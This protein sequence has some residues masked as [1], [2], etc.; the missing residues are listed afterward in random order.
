MKDK[1]GQPINV[2]DFIAYGH[3]RGGYSNS[4]RIG[5]VLRLNEEKGSLTVQGV[6]DDYGVMQLTGSAGNLTHPHRVLVLKQTQVPTIYHDLLDG[7]LT[8]TATEQP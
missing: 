8:Q 1:F 6:D 3:R 4:I 2:G 7:L 5:R